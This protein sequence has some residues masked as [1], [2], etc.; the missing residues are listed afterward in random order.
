FDALSSQIPRFEAEVR[1]TFIAHADALAQARRRIAATILRLRERREQQ[2]RAMDA[3]RERIARSLGALE[4]ESAHG[5]ERNGRLA[6][7]IREISG[8]SQ[9]LVVN[10]QYQDITRQKMEHVGVALKEI[11]AR[12]GVDGHSVKPADLGFLLGTCRVEAMQSRTVARE[13][14]AAFDG[15]AAG[16]REIRGKLDQIEAECWPRAEFKTVV[17]AVQER[18]ANLQVIMKE[19]GELVM[20]SLGT[21]EEAITVI[22]SFGGVAANV[23]NAA[24]EMAES[25]RLIAL[26][27]Q[28]LAAQAG[29]QG[30]GLLVLAERTYAISTE[31]KN[32]TDRIGHEF[33]QS[34]TQL[35]SVVQQCEALKRHAHECRRELETRSQPATRRLD[36]YRDETVKIL[37]TIGAIL[38]KIHEHT[39]A[40]SAS[41]EAKGAFCDPLERLHDDLAAIAVLCEGSRHSQ[42]GDAAGLGEMECRYTMDTERQVHAA[43]LAGEKAPPSV[44]AAHE[45]A[46]GKV[47]ENKNETEP[48]G[49][50]VELF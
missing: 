4:R 29:E 20:L 46:S 16:A 31:I 37:E 40:L 15:I 34:A 3:G 8:S 24:R 48:F 9:G 14:A 42:K 5:R 50:N 22:D 17:G 35:E 26:N 43:A 1:E 23:A 32:I 45:T 7:I 28:V 30:A 13:L 49:G 2:I 47:G 21:V 36:A 39:E 25:M 33:N 27:A 44:L 18:V 12:A 38:G 19:V 41:A 6:H 10:I 11:Q